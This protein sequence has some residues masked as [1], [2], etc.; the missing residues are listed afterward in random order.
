MSGGRR[1]D[2]A[3][4]VR[5][6]GGEEVLLARAYL[7]RVAEPPAPALVG[8][9]EE[10]GPVAAAARVRRGEVPEPVGRET[11]AR[12]PADHAAADLAAAAGCGARL[13]TPEHDDWPQW[14]F[15][16]FAVSA[17]PSSRPRSRC[18]S[19]GPAGS[20]GCASGPSRSWAPGRA[21]PTGG[22]SRRSSAVAAAERGYTVVSGAAIG[23]DGAAHRGALSIG[24]R[25]SRSWRAASTAPTPRRTRPCSTG[26]RAAAWSSASTRPEPSPAKHRFLV[27]NRLI[28]AMAAGVVVV[29]AGLRSGAARTAADAARLG[30]H[31]MAVPGPVTSGVS[32]GCHRMI[33][34]GAEL[35]TRSEEVL[36]SVGRIGL[37]HVHRGARRAQCLGLA[38]G[39]RERADHDRTA[40]GELQEHRIG[41]R[42]G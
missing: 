19:A 26:R 31:V 33:R 15:S 5:A 16:A 6:D 40:A 9:V 34:E 1:D 14:P 30:R 42:H 20:P 21:P 12:R 38:L 7:L 37:E 17:D 22:M 23:I 36:E 13:L 39:D 29:E 32:A 35:V 8:F 2:G 28:A 4:G 18:G 3:A 27:R 11:A 41:E 24:G 25:R 10:L